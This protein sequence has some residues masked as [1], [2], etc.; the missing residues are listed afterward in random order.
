[1]SLFRAIKS[2]LG[3]AGHWI[4]ETYCS[5][6]QKIGERLEQ[7]SDSVA[8]KKYLAQRRPEHPGPSH[9]PVRPLIELKDYR[10]I[11]GHKHPS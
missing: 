1:M 10:V 3:G 8:E 7:I 9:S 2:V 6:G 4:Q 11:N 5:A